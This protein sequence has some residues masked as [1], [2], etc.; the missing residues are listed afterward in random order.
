MDVEV[1]FEVL[2]A[3]D[4]QLFRLHFASIATID[5]VAAFMAVGCECGV[6]WTAEAPGWWL[7]QECGTLV[8]EPG[9]PDKPK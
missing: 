6:L 9:K 3:Y 2:S 5:V 1:P 7:C 8:P 4:L